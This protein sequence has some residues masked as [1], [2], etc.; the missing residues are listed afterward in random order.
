MRYSGCALLILAILVGLAVA[1]RNHGRFGLTSWTG[2]DRIVF[3]A[4]GT[5]QAVTDASALVT[6]V[7]ASGGCLNFAPTQ[8]LTFANLVAF[9]DSCTPGAN[10][11]IVGIAPAY[12]MALRSG[13]PAQERLWT[14]QLG[15]VREVEMPATLAMPVKAWTIAGGEATA[16]D[17]ASNGVAVANAILA[18]RQLGIRLELSD[19][20]GVVAPGAT[21]QVGDLCRVASTAAPGD[22]GAINL[23]YFD[24][25]DTDYAGYWC[26]FPASLVAAAYRD[27]G[28]ILVSFNEAD[29]GT[30]A[31]EIGHALGLLHTGEGLDPELPG[32][33][34][35][36]L[37]WNSVSRHSV[38]ADTPSGDLPHLTLG[39]A[40][41]AAF[42]QESYLNHGIAAQ[43]KGADVRACD[44][45]LAGGACSEN[46][47]RMAS[48]AD[49]VCPRLQLDFPP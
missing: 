36:N 28:A 3:H 29:P 11:E 15:E 32:F 21:S 14:D 47:S 8:S 45:D 33:T 23:F 46:E 9:D 7:Q 1:G 2:N 25:I 6:A 18:A 22:G 49:G 42:G 30:V 20:V 26:G 27:H 43:R 44:C 39:Q 41:R 5:E 4:P 12:A 19:V 17:M 24:D 37:M 34:P 13:S 16:K 48:N 10:E 38:S 35:G 40:Y 31:H